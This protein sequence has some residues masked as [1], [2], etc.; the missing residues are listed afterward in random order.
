M[1]AA[2][3]AAVFP[4]AVGRL[5]L[6]APIGLWREDAPTRLVELSAAGPEEL[7]SFLF[8]DPGS[9]AAQAA[10]ALPADPEAIPAAIAARVWALGCTGKFFWP[11]ADHGLDR[12]LHRVQA[13]T[14]VVWGREDALV[15]SVYAEEFGRL[16]ADSRVEL[17]DGSGHIPQ[18]EQQ[19]AT[20]AVVED[21]LGAG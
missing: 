17:I 6:L 16:I 9:P 4:A 20:L 10:L 15:P 14:L 13:P 21:F 5:V 11:I 19:A 12:R 18:V 7:P 2:D 8:L 3:L 1:L